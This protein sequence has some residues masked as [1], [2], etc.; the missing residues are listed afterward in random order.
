MTTLTLVRGTG[1]DLVPTPRRPDDPGATSAAASLVAE[2]GRT[3]TLEIL[4]ACEP[5]NQLARRIRAVVE[6]LS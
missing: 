1:T 3:G 2:F 6:T 4:A 5:G